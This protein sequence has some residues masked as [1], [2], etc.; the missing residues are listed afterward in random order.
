MNAEHPVPQSPKQRAIDELVDLAQHLR[1]Q[2]KSIVWTNG[3]FEILHAGHIEFLMKA[4]RLGDVFIVGV[5]SD[6]SV[7]ALKGEGHP[8]SGIAERLWVLSAVSCVDYL[9]VFDGPDCVAIL[10][11]LKPDVYVKGFKHL[12]GGL[13]DGERRAVEEARGC[14]ALIGGDPNLSTDAIIRRIRLPERGA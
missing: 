7:R 12:H 4:A 11:A 5:N 13:N 9:T 6:A 8:V 3:C 2:G 10:E 14:I 1:R